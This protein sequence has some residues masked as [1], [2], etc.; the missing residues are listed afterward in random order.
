MTTLPAQHDAALLKAHEDGD[1]KTL[2]ELYGAAGKAALEN[3]DIQQGCFFLTHAYVFALEA[4]APEAA[5]FHKIL[6][7]HGREE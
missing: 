3:G 4:G 1:S 6:K 7:Q 2:I 5:Q